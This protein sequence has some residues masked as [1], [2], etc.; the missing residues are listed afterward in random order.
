MK[1]AYPK[2][3]SFMPRLTVFQVYF[4][5]LKFGHCLYVKFMTL[6]QVDNFITHLWEIGR[7]SGNGVAEPIRWTE[8]FGM[9]RHIEI[10]FLNLAFLKT[11]TSNQNSLYTHM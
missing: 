8:V 10:I 4:I 2:I 3:R 11:P 9:L 5:D 7:F 6:T 1:E